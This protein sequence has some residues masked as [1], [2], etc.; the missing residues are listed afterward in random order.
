MK[1]IMLMVVIAMILSVGVSAEDIMLNI[2]LDFDRINGSVGLY[3]IDVLPSE[4][5][6]EKKICPGVLDQDYNSTYEVVLESSD[7]TELY[8]NC[9]EPLF[10]FTS[11]PPESIEQT[12]FELFL[13]YDS[14]FNYLKVY[15]Q[16]AE[17]LNL[18][19][20]SILC[21]SNEI[22]EYGE[23]YLSCSDCKFYDV[24][25]YCTGVGEIYGV[26]SDYWQDNY[27]DLDCFVDDDCSVE[28]C[29]DGVQNGD[30]TGIDSGGACNI[31]YCGDGIRNYDEEGVDCGGACSNECVDIDFWISAWLTG[32][33]LDLEGIIKVVD[34]YVNL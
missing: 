27:C 13:P 18:D 1:K 25:G 23:N 7:F 31:I 21:D 8:D 20:S 22:C 5:E 34:N 4:I 33:Q 3:S 32:K 15:N 26:E 24:D 2:V 30:E 6:T 17:K 14:N 9:I 16:G 29:N 19:I 11:I 12:L 28:N 10:Y